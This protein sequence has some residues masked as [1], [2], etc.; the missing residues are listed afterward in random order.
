MAKVLIADNS[1]RDAERLRTLLC[2]LDLTAEV[3]ASGA[4]AEELIEAGTGDL[5]AAII[6]WEIP[7][8]PSGFELLTRCRQRMPATPVVVVSGTLDAALAARAHALGAQDFLEKPLDTERVKSCVESLLAVQDPLSPLV[9]RLRELMVGES[10]A[11]TATLKQVARAIPRTDL[12]ILLVGESGTGKELLARAIHQLSPSADKPWV[13]V[14]VGAIPPKLGESALFGHEKG[15][16]TDANDRHIGYLEE[17]GDGTLFLDEIGELELSLQVKLLRALQ[18]KE[19]RRIKGSKPLPFRARLVCATNRDL[20]AEVSRGAFRA[21]LYHRIAE[22]IVQVP[23]LRER[24][25]DL[26]ALL[27]HFLRAHAGARSLRLAR[28]TLTILRSYHFPGNIRELDNIIRAAVVETDG[29]V[30]LPRHLPLP[31]MKSFL[32]AKR[33]AARQAEETSADSQPELAYAAL[34]GEVQ[35]ALPANWLE[36]PYR[37]AAQLSARAFDRIYLQRLLERCHH[38]V[39]RAA[40]IAG[41]DVKTFRKR[42]RDCGLPPLGAGEEHSDA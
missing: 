26:D 40:A 9:M 27:K 20:T 37:E 1:E 2:Q 38:K 4:E 42:W 5:A 7:G 35:K 23:P 36:L 15:A 22:R 29:E 21:D 30:L 25:G 41:V 10:T 33:A 11:F 34:L 39:S 24:D 19:F 14:N 28:E 31:Q 13:A 6:L 12:R 32:D 18:E 16:F 8:P 17:S 3:C